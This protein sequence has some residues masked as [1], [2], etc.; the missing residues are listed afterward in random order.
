[1]KKY[2]KNN[3]IIGV[4]L[5]LSTLLLTVLYYIKGLI[6]ENPISF[7]ENFI[8]IFFSIFGVV[9]CSGIFMLASDSIFCREKKF[10]ERFFYVT[11]SLWLSQLI[12]LPVSIILLLVNFIFNLDVFIINKI[13]VFTISYA[14]QIFL[15]FSYKFVTKHD[16]FTT[17]K[18]VTSQGILTIL[19]ILLLKFI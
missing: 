18:V 8:I 17:I 11:K 5:L 1:M 9:F 10:K 14:S 4:F 6:Q 7:I 19:I 13:I 2:L 16:W 3:I 12:I 15:F